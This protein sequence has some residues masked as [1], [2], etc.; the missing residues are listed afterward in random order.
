M[1]HSFTSAPGIS[2]STIGHRRLV[3]N[4]GDLKNQAQSDKLGVIGIKFFCRPSLFND[5]RT[6]DEIEKESPSGKYVQQ[7]G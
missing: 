7:K 6:W 5:A 2:L 1:V 4:F 3:S